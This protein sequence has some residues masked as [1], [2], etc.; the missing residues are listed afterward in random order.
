MWA[1]LIW[2]HVANQLTNDATQLPCRQEADGLL[3]GAGSALH[4]L[5]KAAHGG[6]ERVLGKGKQRKPRWHIQLNGA[7]MDGFAPCSGVGKTAWRKRH[8]IAVCRKRNAR[9]QV[10]QTVTREG[11]GDNV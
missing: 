3:S 1:S 8:H 7:D 10:T 4:N 11:G 9:R 6:A 5:N 2:T